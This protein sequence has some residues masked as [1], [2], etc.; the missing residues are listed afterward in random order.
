MQVKVINN[1]GLSST[2]INDPKL[3]KLEIRIGSATYSVSER[4]G[5]LCISVD[6]QISVKPMGS[7]RVLLSDQS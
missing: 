1:D 6:T 7:N 4:D 5:E 2:E 3:L